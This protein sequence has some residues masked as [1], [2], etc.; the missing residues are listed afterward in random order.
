MPRK[1]IY[2]ELLSPCVH[3][4][5]CTE[6]TIWV[7]TDIMNAALEMEVNILDVTVHIPEHNKQLLA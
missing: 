5:E 2:V 6:H 1:Y 4:M 7:I 3:S